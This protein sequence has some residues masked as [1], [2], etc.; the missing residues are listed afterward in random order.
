MSAAWTTILA[1]AVVTAAIK[2]SGPIVLGNRELAPWAR[3]LIGL[4][5]PALLAAFV[6]VETFGKHKEVVLDAR[7]A[8]LAAA[9]LALAARLSVLWA[10][11]VAALTTALVRALF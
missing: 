8:G 2:A 7:A 3:R 10:V 9:A 6:V 11:G 5:A 4:L 1:L